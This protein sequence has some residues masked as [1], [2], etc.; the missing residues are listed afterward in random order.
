MT[1]HFLQR[2]QAL[3]LFDRVATYFFLII[4]LLI[5]L[6]QHNMEMP[7]RRFFYQLGI[8]AVIILVIPALDSKRNR[9]FHFMRN[10]YLILGITFI[11]WSVG[12]LIHLITPQLL[13]HHIISFEKALFG[14]LPN[15]WIQRLENPFLTEIMQLSYAIYWFTIPVGAAIFYFKRRYDVFEYMLFFTLITFFLS[16]LFFILIPVAGPRFMIVDEISAPYQ[17]IFVTRLLRGFVETTGLRGGAFPSSHV[18]VAIVILFF[19]WKYYPKIGKRCF[20]PA[21]IALSIATVYGQYHYV[22]DVIVGAAMGVLIGKIGIWYTEKRLLPQD[23]SHPIRIEKK[24]V[25]IG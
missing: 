22:T 7:F 11:Y 15:I 14:T 21:V 9:L 6:F 2:W 24:D 25:L 23:R 16:Y 8:I 4:N 10:W 13:D 5:V 17:G 12:D 3:K 1:K 18:A 20:L 19:V